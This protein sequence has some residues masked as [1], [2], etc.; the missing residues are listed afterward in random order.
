MVDDTYVG[1]IYE[2]IGPVKAFNGVPRFGHLDD[3]SQLVLYT[4][5][6]DLFLQNLASYVFGIIF[7]AAF[8]LTSYIVLLIMIS[9]FK[10]F[11]GS[12]IPILAGRPFRQE[13][14]DKRSVTSIIIRAFLFFASIATITSGFLFVSKGPTS[15]RA[16][17]DDIHDALDVS[18]LYSDNL[19]V[20]FFNNIFTNK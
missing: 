10:C 14:K 4:D 13:R 3:I 8:L 12:M 2:A 18:Q 7:T 15:V 1:P 17:A 19:M 5:D 9:I 20:I 6:E 16:I 11:C